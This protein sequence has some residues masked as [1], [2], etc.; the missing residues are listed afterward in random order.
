MP[1]ADT[2]ANLT[3]NW[4]T[5]GHFERELANNTGNRQPPPA[6]AAHLPHTDPFQDRE[7]THLMH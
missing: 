3:G 5:Q 7:L 4:P 2:L 6:A 1:S